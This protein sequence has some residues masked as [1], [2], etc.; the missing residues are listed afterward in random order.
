MKVTFL[1]EQKTVDV[2]KGISILDAAAIAGINIKSVC[3][4]AGTCGKCKVELMNGESVLAC[5]TFI[6]EKI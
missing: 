4:G 2:E 5:N 6:I 1:P 3:G